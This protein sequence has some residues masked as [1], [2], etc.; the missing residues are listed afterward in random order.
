MK[1]RLFLLA[2][3]I[4]SLLQVTILDSFKLFSVKPDFLLVMIIIASLFL[5]WKQAI[6]F[7]VVA[8]SLKD[9]FSINT[10]GLNIFLFALWS[11]LV[12]KLS[13]KI[14]LENNMLRGAIVFVVIISNAVLIYSLALFLGNS[15]IS[16]GVF[17]R[18]MFLEAIYAALISPLVFIAL[19]PIIS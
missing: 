5:E 10:F 9:I 19:K 8:G 15:G 12:T 7:A 4:V 6:F 3:F 11:Y 13:R 1:I 16:A 14:S 17:L 18:V 2:V